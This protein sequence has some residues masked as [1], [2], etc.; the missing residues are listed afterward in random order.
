MKKT[1]SILILAGIVSFSLS[2]QNLPFE[3]DFQTN[4][5]KAQAQKA[6][7]IV[8]NSG[9]NCKSISAFVVSKGSF[10]SGAEYSLVCNEYQY[11]YKIQDKGG[12]A[13]VTV[14]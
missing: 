14:D 1:S 2:A 12:K 6:A 13:V 5:T 10:G 8:K 3:S 4:G 9:Y 7:S 11:S